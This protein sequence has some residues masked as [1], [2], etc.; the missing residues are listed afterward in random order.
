MTAHRNPWT[1]GRHWQVF[2]V[3]NPAGPL[4]ETR[5]VC[6]H[7]TRR[8]ATACAWTRDTLAVLRNRGATPNESYSI[9]RTPNGAHR[10]DEENGIPCSVSG[11]HYC[12]RL[13]TWNGHP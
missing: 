10:I 1:P 13:G 7:T 8:T 2:A 9:R 4:P 3:P 11:G 12:P 5:A 6:S